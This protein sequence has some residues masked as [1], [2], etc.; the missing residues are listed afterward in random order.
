MLRPH[1]PRHQRGLFIHGRTYLRATLGQPLR[2][3]PA[4]VLAGLAAGA[5]PAAL[6]CSC[7]RPTGCMASRGIWGE[8]F[9]RDPLPFPALRFGLRLPVPP[10][11]PLPAR[12]T[13]CMPNCAIH[14]ADDGSRGWCGPQ[15]YGRGHG[16]LTRQDCPHAAPRMRCSGPSARNPCPR[17]SRRRG[18]Q[19]L[20]GKASLG[21]VHHGWQPI[22]PSIGKTY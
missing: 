5:G 18:R 20:R 2:L 19:V 22:S 1:G 16:P 3:H 12:I 8:G 15:P 11:K 6:P 14:S 10:L 13:T 9:A 17:G 21:S 7:P 4:S